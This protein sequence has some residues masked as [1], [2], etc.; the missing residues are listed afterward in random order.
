MKNISVAAAVISFF[1]QEFAVAQEEHEFE[2]FNGIVFVK[3]MVNDK[4]PFDFIFDTGAS[5]T[6]LKPAFAKEQGIQTDKKSGAPGANLFAVV[7]S[8]GMGKSQVKD[9]KVAV[10]AVPQVDLPL[11]LMGKKYCGILG[12]NYISRFEITMNYEKKFIRLVPTNFDPGDPLEQAMGGFRRF[13]GSES[14][15]VPRVG[16]TYETITE[17]SGGI[18]ILKIAKG[19]AAEIAGLK[20]GD[21]ITKANGKKISNG[22]DWRSVLKDAKKEITVTVARGDEEKTLAVKIK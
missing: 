11:S 8:I 6:V 9:L 20:V 15:K 21:C 7:K 1:L 12:F 2:L 14:K 4:G 18:K 22:E 5:V 13:T 17:G 3:V 16:F 10:M 19:S